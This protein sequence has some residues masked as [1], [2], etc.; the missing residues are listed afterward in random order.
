MHWSLETFGKFNLETSKKIRNENLKRLQL[1][2]AFSSENLLKATQGLIFHDSKIQFNI[3][4]IKENIP[5]QGGI[6]TIGIF[7]FFTFFI[8]AQKI[9]FLFIICVIALLLYLSCHVFGNSIIG[10]PKVNFKNLEEDKFQINLQFDKSPEKFKLLF[11]YYSVE[12]KVTDRRGTSNIVHTNT[13]YR[14]KDIRINKTKRVNELNFDFPPPQIPISTQFDDVEIQWLFFYR[15]ELILGL[16]YLYSKK[17]KWSKLKYL[18]KKNEHP[19]LNN[20][21]NNNLKNL[22]LQLKQLIFNLLFLF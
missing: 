13:L 17:W 3:L 19:F 15:I 11:A 10:I 22:N 12:E 7:L 9:Y 6:F 4:N 21:E 16:E 14:S 18:C 20:V 2:N 5:S 8:L 1:L